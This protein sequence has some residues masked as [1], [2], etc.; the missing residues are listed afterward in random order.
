MLGS[1][2]AC[3]ARLRHAGSV[4]EVTF[5]RRR[6]SRD[7]VY[8]TREDGTS[9]GWD[10]PSYGDGLP[11]DLSHLV[12]EDALRLAD[13]FWG[14]VDQG[15]EVGVVDNQ[16]TLVRDGKRFAG[17]AGADFAGLNEA[18]AAVAVLAGPAVTHSE[19]GE[20]AVARLASPL[21][22]RL[23]A[24]EIAEVLGARSYPRARRPTQSPPS[25]TDSGRSVS[26]GGIS[27]TGPRSSSRSQDTRRDHRRRSS[28][29]HAAAACQ[30]GARTRVASPRR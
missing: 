21:G 25:A 4:L 7:R 20:V 1:S 26:S 12:V 10:F 17:E 24:N 5:V 13:G 2:S 18:E 30:S 29:C 3:S 27:T 8:V 16:A 6:G 23:L 28:H 9:T 15:V 14:L 19:V 22:G 11:H